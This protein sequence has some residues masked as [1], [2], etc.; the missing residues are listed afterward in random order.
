MEE[1]PFR[2]DSEHRDIPILM[3]MAGYHFI[4]VVS[5]R[6]TPGIFRILFP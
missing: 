2:H 6:A 3:T 4:P 5:I 1:I